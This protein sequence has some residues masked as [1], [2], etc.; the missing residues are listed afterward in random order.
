M[1]ENGAELVLN[2]LAKSC[3]LESL[4]ISEHD[5][6]GEW[7][8]FDLHAVSSPE[9]GSECFTYAG[10]QRSILGVDPDVGRIIS[11]RVKADDVDAFR[12]R[13][14]CFILMYMMSLAQ[15]DDIMYIGSDWQKYVLIRKGTALEELQV[16]ADLSI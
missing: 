16:I 8:S 1:T 11:M 10:C 4:K 6:D 12:M 5:V 9:F 15:V 13:K 3:G 7:T 14:S 2:A